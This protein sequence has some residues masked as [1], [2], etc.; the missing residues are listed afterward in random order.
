MWRSGV[1][2]RVKCATWDELT[3]M[4][5]RDEAGINSSFDLR[6]DRDETDTDGTDDDSN[7]AAVV[8]F[9]WGNVSL[10]SNEVYETKPQW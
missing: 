6:S 10:L 9:G 4:E 3:G 2:P 7:A 8:G 5:E 1:V